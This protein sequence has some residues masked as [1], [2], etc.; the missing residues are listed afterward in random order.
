MLQA[1]VGVSL[2]GNNKPNSTPTPPSTSSLSLQQQFQL[3]HL[4]EQLA[5]YSK[6]AQE[7][8]T[9][10][11]HVAI[12]IETTELNIQQSSPATQ[13]AMKTRIIE[14]FKNFGINIFFTSDNLIKQTN[15]QPLLQNIKISPH[16][17][18]QNSNLGQAQGFD[19]ILPPEHHSIHLSHSSLSH[20]AK[21]TSGLDTK[22]HTIH[23][24]RRTLR[25]LQEQARQRQETWKRALELAVDAEK[26][27][28]EEQAKKDIEEEA[29]AVL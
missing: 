18:K 23:G 25:M 28:L 19:V 11:S 4:L 8:W 29:G 10:D 7:K 22:T 26:K 5:L 13:N 24:G 20:N 2:F 27:R 3:N 16:A 6:Q 14:I 21:P 15:T 12:L 1:S 9:Q 17:K